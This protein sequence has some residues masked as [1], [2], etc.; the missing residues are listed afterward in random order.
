MIATPDAPNPKDP[1]QMDPGSER[2]TLGLDF[3]AKGRQDL[4][5]QRVQLGEEMKR[6]FGITE[7]LLIEY[8]FTAGCKGFHS[9]D[10]V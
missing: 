9:K 2:E 10:P 3:G 1:N 5:K 6:D 4:P 8:G 7:R